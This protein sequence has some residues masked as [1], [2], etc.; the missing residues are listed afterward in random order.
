MA[1]ASI[2]ADSFLVSSSPRSYRK[3][4][5]P[6]ESIGP[7]RT[8][9]KTQEYDTQWEPLWWIDRTRRISD[10]PT[11][12]TARW[13][14]ILAASSM[15][16]DVI[17]L[18]IVYKRYRL[19]TLKPGLN[20]CKIPQTKTDG[21]KKCKKQSII[22]FYSTIETNMVVEIKFPIIYC[23]LK[24]LYANKKKSGASIIDLSLTILF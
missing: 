5:A 3:A 20:G 23:N 16:S 7:R 22:R 4:G 18:I 11:R 2:V 12:F 9:Q 21:N 15:V 14:S 13:L 6:C 24:K 10:V 1:I 17:S 8:R 19:W